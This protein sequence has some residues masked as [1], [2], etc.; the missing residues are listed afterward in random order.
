[1]SM[2]KAMKVEHL[3]LLEER[4]K[5]RARTDFYAFCQYCFTEGTWQDNWH[6][7]RIAQK[8]QEVLEG[9]VKRLI[10]SIP[11]RHGKSQLASRFFPAFALG[12]NPNLNIIGA[13]NAARLATKMSKDAKKVINSKE[14][15]CVFPDTRVNV[16]GVRTA[17]G[18]DYV[19]TQGEWE[20]IGGHG[21]YLSRGVSQAIQGAGA[22]I[23]VLDDLFGSREDAQSE[24]K[25]EKVIDWF[26]DDVKSR[27]TPDGAIVII[28]TRK[29]MDDLVGHVLSEM[30]RSPAADQW[31]VMNFPALLETEEERHPLDPRQIGEALWP[32]KKSLLELEALKEL[33]PDIFHTAYQGKPAPPGGSVIKTD[34]TQKRWFELPASFDTIIQSW[35][36]RNGGKGKDSSYA[37]GQL[38]G[39]KGPDA[40]LIDQVRGRWDFPETME[41]LRS[42]LKDD[43][44]WKKARKVLIEDKAD[45][46]TAIPVLK[47]EFSRIEPVT[48]VGSKEERL[49]AVS[50]YWATGNVIL[51]G[52]AVWV[53][54]HVHEVTTFPGASNDDQVDASTQALEELFHGSNFAFVID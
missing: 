49:S 42:K 39:K 12:V 37:V 1:M 18:E 24:A 32:H 20:V 27:L 46:R 43:K 48:P 13:S 23:I 15:R 3:F 22:D 19:N 38:W 29:H 52:N 6:L 50:A 16:T 25:R 33:R 11:Y 41:M 40:Y 17:P 9:K 51:P 54:D 53:A 8:L 21:S 7:Q 36:L 35:D 5:R 26:E 34:W 4:A 31:E 45:G 28:E 10:I 14:Y 44:L 30:K 47:K 2:T